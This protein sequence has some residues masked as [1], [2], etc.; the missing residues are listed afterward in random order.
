[1]SA[2]F[3][4][5]RRRNGAILIVALV[6]TFTM[7]GMVLMLCQEMRTESVAAGNR[8]ASASAQAIERGA[9]QYLLGMIASEGQD[10][11][12][13]SE[14]QFD[15]VQVG[16]GYFWVLR[17]QY[18]DPAMPVFGLVSE[19]AKVNLNA[20][21]LDA[22]YQLP[23]QNYTV[24]S[25]VMDWVD[26]DEDVQGDGAESDYYSTL[27][28][29]YYAKNSAFDT[30]D[31]LLMVRG[32]TRDLLYGDG[33]APPLGQQSG[34][35]VRDVA[36]LSNDPAIARGWYDLVTVYSSEPNRNVDGQSRLNIAHNNRSMRVALQT[37]L[38]TRLSSARA[39]AIVSTI[40]GRD[41]SDL[42][43]FYTRARLTSDEFDKIYDDLT[44][45]TNATL[46]GRININEA[47]RSVLATLPGIT[48]ADVDKLI[49][50]RPQIGASDTSGMGW[51]ATALTPA[52]AAQL[53]LGTRLTARSYQYSA[54]ILAVSG[55][56]RAFS[57]VRVVFDNSS[58]TPQ[59]VY[60]RDVTDRGWPMDPQILASLRSGQSIGVAGYG[61]N[62]MPAM[63]G[64]HG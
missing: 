28:D 4:Y 55:N 43:E 34:I 27:P 24:A 61:G 36:S 5:P 31:E 60:R 45:S 26:G 39:D 16:D 20:T 13:V 22:L 50:A 47:P 52:R 10:V 29:P 64:S 6:V 62:R 25:S 54:D 1:M 33:T 49:A 30:V 11:T 35:V 38:R 46:K 17:P 44:T 2:R 37:R 9:E 15:A 41:M 53:R 51:I 56:G 21:T 58:G 48:D 19:A 7:C 63:G 40:G 12:T 42:F 57:R 18:D 14:D 23:G 8:A 32:V 59:I 3:A